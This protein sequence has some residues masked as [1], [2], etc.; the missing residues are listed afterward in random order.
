MNSE[1]MYCSHTS[2]S[3]HGLEYFVLHPSFKRPFSVGKNSNLFYYLRFCFT[4]PCKS[5]LLFRNDA[6]RFHYKL[7][8][9]KFVTFSHTWGMKALWSY[10]ENQV[11]RFIWGNGVMK[12][13]AVTLSVPKSIYGFPLILS[14]NVRFKKRRKCWKVA[15]LNNYDSVIFQFC[16]L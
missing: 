7:Q 15:V 4:K 9:R 2:M 8:R 12:N 16:F 3:L 1:T 11:W 14:F 13:V 5:V 6:T 10:I